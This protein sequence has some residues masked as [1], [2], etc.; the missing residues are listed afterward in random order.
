MPRENGSMREYREYIMQIIRTVLKSTVLF[1]VVPFHPQSTKEMKCDA[2]DETDS[3]ATKSRRNEVVPFHPQVWVCIMP[4]TAAY[5]SALLPF[6]ED[7][8]DNLKVRR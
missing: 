8:K 5:I 4:A 2:L 3:E 7:L 1:I 6:K